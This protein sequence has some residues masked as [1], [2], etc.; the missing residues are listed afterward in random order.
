MCSHCGVAGH[1][2]EKCYKVH[3]YSPGF[4]FTRNTP[5]SYSTNQV[6][7]QGTNVS[8]PHSQGTDLSGPYSQGIDLSG[9]HSHAPQL[10]SP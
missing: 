7:M 3:G 5:V 6:Q 9:H 10:S 2:V 4:K 8:S 1:T